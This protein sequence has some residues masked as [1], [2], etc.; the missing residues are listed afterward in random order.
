MS[1]RPYRLIAL[2]A[3]GLTAEA[4]LA[5]QITAF[6]SISVADGRSTTTITAE[7]RDRNGRIVADGTRVVFSSTLGTFRESV[8]TTAGGVA[9]A[10]L[11]AGGTAGIAKITTTPLSGG[12]S[13]STF[14]FE[15]AA[16][17]ASLSSAKEYVELVAPGVMRYTADNRVIGASGPDKGVK[18]RYRDI[19]IEANDLQYDIARYEIRARKARLT[20]GKFT[21]DFEELYFRLNARQGVGT[22]D[23]K[24]PQRQVLRMQGTWL[25]L[26]TERKDGTFAFDPPAL[27]DRFGVVNIKGPSITPSTT[28]PQESMFE[29]EEMVGSPS[30][31]AAKKAVIFPNKQIQFQRAEIY[32]ADKRVMKLPLFQVN[33][34]QAANSPMVTDQIFHMQDSQVEVNFPIFLS[35]KPGQ[36]NVLRLRT[37]ETYGRNS[38]T[39]RG[40]YLDYEMN[41][42]RGDDFDGGFAIR[43]IGRT[44]WTL[45]LQQYIRL[46]DRSAASAQ[47][48][49]PGARSFFGS[50]SINRQFDGYQVSLSGNASRT[51]QGIRSSAHDMAL[52][53]ETNPIKVAHGSPFQ[54]YYGFTAQTMS[55]SLIGSVQES[56]GFRSRIQSS[57]IPLTKTTGIATG[58]SANFVRGQNVGDGFIFNSNTTLTQRIPHLG[59]VVFSYDFTRDAYNDKYMGM[60]RLGVQ[61]YWDLGPFDVNLY[62]SRS[63]DIERTSLFGDFSYRLSPLWR[64]TSSYTYD[65]YLNTQFLDY[66]L[67]IG[68]RIGWREIG[69]IW[70]E[71]TKRIGIQ[72]LGVTVN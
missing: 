47:I 3:V 46:D 6:P 62:G 26:A 61:T 53:A 11:V 69:L 66:N 38:T 21:K 4:V 22:T 20:I 35:L 36:T 39:S 17:R 64:L 18:L 67:A 71:R 25:G 48:E 19:Q 52:V 8:V 9:R 43:N 30:S 45:G 24:A 31:I 54:M 16:D 27:Q 23:F 50:S 37:G 49:M 70:S 7:V 63:L 44:D 56:A 65:R 34:Q 55:N 10:I 72:F 60:H 2:A 14:E 15:F 5:D 12:G 32:V 42:N 13:P 40:A 59:P 51:L 33:F 29:I 57:T 1:L 41:W 68:Y 28:V 58:F